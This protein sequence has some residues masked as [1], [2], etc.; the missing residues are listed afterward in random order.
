MP[1]TLP[2]ERAPDEMTHQASEPIARFVGVS[3]DC[4]DPAALADF[5]LG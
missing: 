1:S 4:T 5:Y 3:L 2:A